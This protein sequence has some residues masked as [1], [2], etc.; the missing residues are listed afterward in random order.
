MF[1]LRYLIKP[2]KVRSHYNFFRII[3][4]TSVTK[5]PQIFIICIFLLSILESFQFGCIHV[6]SLVSI[7][8]QIYIHVLSKT[9]KMS[10][11]TLKIFFIPFVFL[12]LFN[13]IVI[14]KD[15]L[16]LNFQEKERL[17]EVII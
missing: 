4:S 2:T 12:L 17:D 7:C 8:I 6:F 1:C 13:S 11:K 3:H 5:N 10:L 16:S 15:F 14:G 9:R